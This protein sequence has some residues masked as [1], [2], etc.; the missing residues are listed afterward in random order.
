MI[1]KENKGA[2]GPFIL[3]TKSGTG[4]SFFAVSWAVRQAQLGRQVC[5]TLP[6]T[7]KAIYMDHECL[8][9]EIDARFKE[10]LRHDSRAH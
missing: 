7:F 1:S 2:N 4:M 6:I 9:S 3:V 10:I 8:T 5:T